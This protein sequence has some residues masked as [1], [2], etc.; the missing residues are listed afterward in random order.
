MEKKKK[1]EDKIELSFLPI[2]PK[3]ESRSLEA[4]I[5][6]KVAPLLEESMEK[7]WGITIPKIETDLTDR[8]KNAPFNFYIP[9]HA[10][11]Q[12]AKKVFK[13]EFLKRELQQHLGNVSQLAKI[14]GVDRRSLHRTMKEFDIKRHKLK[15]ENNSTEKYKENAIDQTLR[16]TLENYKD[17]IQPQKMEQFYQDLPSLSRNIAKFLPSPT[18]TWKEAEHEFERQFLNQALRENEGNIAKASQKIKI[19]AETLHRK[20]KKLGL[21]R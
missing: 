2:Y 17:I 19:R 12:Q 9:P 8:L 3:E 14:L 6:E 1:N 13:R 15:L 18:L 5:K 11:F 21:K 20:V 7:N 10:T 16:S 4:T